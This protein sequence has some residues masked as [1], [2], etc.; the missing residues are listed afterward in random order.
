MAELIKHPGVTLTILLKHETTEGLQCSKTIAQN[1]L[2]S[3][4]LSAG[5]IKADQQNR[6]AIWGSSDDLP[7]QMNP[8]WIVLQQ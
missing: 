2:A 8:G 4:L 6:P 3:C 1:T 7:P 5:N